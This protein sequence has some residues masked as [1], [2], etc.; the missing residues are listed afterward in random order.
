[1]SGSQCSDAQAAIPCVEKTELPKVELSRPQE[2][3][4]FCI[5]GA[6]YSALGAYNEWYLGH[7]SKMNYECFTD[8][9]IKKYRAF[10]RKLGYKPGDGDFPCLPRED[11]IR[12]G[13]LLEKMSLLIDEYKKEGK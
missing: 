10:L 11:V 9:G 12:V 7:P 8:L 6:G 1:M 5:D 3:R 4:K 13:E 2:Q